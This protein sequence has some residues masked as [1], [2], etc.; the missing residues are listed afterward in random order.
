M[1]RRS[2]LGDAVVIIPV[3]DHVVLDVHEDM[4]EAAAL[5]RRLGFVL[6]PR[7]RHTLGSINH[8]AMFGTDYL[9]L[10]GWPAD[11]GTARPELQSWP[12]GLNGLVFKTDDADATY[13]HLSAAGLAAGP[14]RSFSRP[15]ALAAGTQDARFRTVHVAADRSPIGRV[16]FCEHLTPELVWRPEWQAH[17]NGAL[18]IDSLVIAA[19]APEAVA[20]LFRAMFGVAGSFAAGRARIEIVADPGGGRDRMTTLRL[21]RH[22]PA[23]AIEAAAAGNVRLEFVP[24]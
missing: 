11:G 24:A 3:L 22:G 2:T 9:E 5:Y 10:L 8:L 6:T 14:P 1:V 15:V 18:A 7:G 21:L 16:Y 20:A 19:A 12:R 4:D 17:A 13:A 23:A